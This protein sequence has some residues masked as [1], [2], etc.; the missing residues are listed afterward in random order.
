LIILVGW[1]L[2]MWWIIVFFSLKAKLNSA[3]EE[4]EEE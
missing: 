2:T 1:L 4:D 3:S